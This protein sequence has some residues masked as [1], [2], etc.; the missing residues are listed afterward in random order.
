MIYQ[1]VL[2]IFD[3]VIVY[4]I[5]QY[6]STASQLHYQQIGAGGGVIKCHHRKKKPYLADIQL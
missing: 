2:E 6:I 5:Q 3:P 1:I 4:L